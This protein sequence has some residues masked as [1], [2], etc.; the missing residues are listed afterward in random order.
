MP[1]NQNDVRVFSA[2]QH[3]SDELA[4]LTKMNK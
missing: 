1:H 3:R 4:L 2:F